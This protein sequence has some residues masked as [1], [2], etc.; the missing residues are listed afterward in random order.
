MNNIKNI[1]FDFDGT[2]ANTSQGVKESVAFALDSLHIIHSSIGDDVIGPSP[3]YLYNKVFNLDNDIAKQA[4]ILHRKYSNDEAYKTAIIYD[5]VQC[6]LQYLKKRGIKL[7][8]VSLKKESVINKIL[9][10]NNLH[11]YFDKIVGITIDETLSKIDLLKSVKKLIDFNESIYVGDTEQD[12]N[13][14]KQINLRFCFAK[15]GFGR[16]NKKCFYTIDTFSDILGL[17]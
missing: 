13:C 5:G 17:I 16:V 9:I 10:K 3:F 6:C 14:C 11:D 8:I 1:I 12:Y 2:L 7:F 15:Y 4:V